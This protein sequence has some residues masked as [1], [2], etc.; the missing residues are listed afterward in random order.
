VRKKFKL[1]QSLTEPIARID[2]DDKICCRQL[3]LMLHIHNGDSTAHTAKAAS[4]P[5]DHFP[6][7]E[8]LVCGPTPGDLSETDFLKM[9][10]QH[11]SGSYQVPFDKCL[12]ELR[13]MHEALASFAEH[14][15]VV[16]WFEH[17]LFCQ[18]Q[19]I[20]L[21]NW[22]AAREMGETKLSLVC[23][24][25]FPGVQPFHGLGELNQEQ[26]Q[27]LYPGRSNITAAQLELAV[28]AWGA[29]SSA[30][31]RRL[32]ALLRSD[33]SA[34][35]FLR[36]AL[37]KHLERFPSTRNGLGRVENTTLE[38]IPAGYKKF[39]S[40]FPAFSRRE[41]AYGFGDAQVYLAMEGMMSARKPLLV[42][43]VPDHW[44]R[45]S[46]QIL[47]AS[48]ELTDDGKAVLAGEEDFVLTN[49]IDTWLGG[50]HL[51]GHEAD[52]RWDEDSQQLLVSL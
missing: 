33:T 22:F 13:A 49:G 47:L 17:D 32:I 2:F 45:D 18:V 4:I 31:A 44:S 23:I 38:L 24:D 35:P 19:L 27:S 3:T 11:L 25:H 51:S 1:N 28:R 12:A 34:L 46:A 36:D 26:L 39:R 48:F 52:W 9:R 29:Y 5:G 8:A 41:S 42:Q 40:L 20:Y 10:A 15:E 37:K 21:L 6:W 30:D 50:I 7:R 43:H 16:L 14:E